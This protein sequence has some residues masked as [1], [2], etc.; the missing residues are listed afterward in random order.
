[1]RY[2]TQTFKDLS[3]KDIKNNFPEF[4][5]VHHTGGSDRNPLADSSNQ[6]VFDVENWHKSLNWEGIGYHFFI[7]K[8]GQVSL[9][10]PEWHNGAHTKGYNMKSLGICLAGNFDITLPTAGQVTSLRELLKE[11]SQKYNIDSSKI[12][13]HRTHANKTCYGKNLSD[14][15]AKDLLL[16]VVKIQEGGTLCS[17]A[18]SEKEIQSL[19]KVIEKQSETINRQGS[20]IELL[21]AII[22]K[23][24]K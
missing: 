20:T 18:V 5:I 8:S 19:G 13:P 22:K 9:G 23:I 10:R 4:L 6:S 24:F 21:T 16:P 7:D 15:W 17:Y 12:I 11:L 2:E 14:S 3:K 1:M